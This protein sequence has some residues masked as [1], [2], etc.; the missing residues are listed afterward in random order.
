MCRRIGF[1]TLVV[2]SLLVLPAIS[3]ADSFTYE[4]T[5]SVGHFSFTEPSLIT[6]NQ[7][8]SILPFKLQGAAFVYA[9][10]SFLTE[11]GQNEICFLFG[12]SN[13]SGD[14]NSASYTPPFSIFGAEFLAPTSVGTFTSFADF[15][16]RTPVLGEPCIFPAGGWSLMISQGSPVPEPSSLVLFGSG[17]LTVL[18]VMRKKLRSLTRFS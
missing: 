11:N 4:L 8:L 15:C 17:A 3:R 13:V 18:A 1:S 16:S 12:T 2:A 10:V 7:T 9:S 6:T 5:S 14:C